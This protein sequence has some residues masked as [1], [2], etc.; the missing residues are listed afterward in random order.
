MAVTNKA[1]SLSY[2]NKRFLN[3]IVSLLVTFL[4]SALL[5]INSLIYAVEYS[6][7]T[8]HAFATTSRLHALQLLQSVAG[9]DDLIV[10]TPTAYGWT[11]AST[12]L[13]VVMAS[14]PPWGIMENSAPYNKLRAALNLMSAQSACDVYR[15][16]IHLGFPFI[17]VAKEDLWLQWINVTSVTRASTV[18]YDGPDTLIIRPI[19]LKAVLASMLS[20]AL[21]INFENVTEAGV[22]DLA[23]QWRTIVHGHPHPVSGMVGVGLRFDGID[24]YLVLEA[25]RSIDHLFKDGISVSMWLKGSVTAD[26]RDIFSIDRTFKI[27]W[28]ARGGIGALANT[29]IGWNRSNL[30]PFA[31]PTEQWVHVIVTFDPKL[32]TNNFALY[33]NGELREVVSKPGEIISNGARLVI[34][35]RDESGGLPFKGELDHLIVIN[36][37]IRD[38]EV[39]ALYLFNCINH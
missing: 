12:R 19:N 5:F 17:V 39:K 15:E 27:Y 36:R 11:I 31:L 24:D 35:A 20:N 10:T 25:S 29:I 4:L 2:P 16:A 30:G 23:G 38:E 8:D 13:R 32:P 37:P 1:T 28:N 6:K 34:G 33:V 26:D 18:I 7:K 22:V 9:I 21:I 3:V 14:Q